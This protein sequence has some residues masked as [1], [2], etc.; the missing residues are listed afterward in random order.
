MTLYRT[1]P[2]HAILYMMYVYRTVRYRAVLKSKP[3]RHL[4]KDRG[5]TTIY[6]T[7]G[8]VQYGIVRHLGRYVGARCTVLE[9]LRGRINYVAALGHKHMHG[10]GIRLSCKL[11]T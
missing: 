1:D 3:I 10:F 11:A 2:Y 5:E 9:K 8:A 6:R 4:R 7:Y